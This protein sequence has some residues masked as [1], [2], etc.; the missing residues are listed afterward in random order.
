VN[1]KKDLLQNIATFSTLPLKDVNKNHFTN[2]LNT[3]LVLI[4]SFLYESSAHE[5]FNID[6]AK[7]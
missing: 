3:L 4:T 5:N 1:L 6:V 2:H 7:Y